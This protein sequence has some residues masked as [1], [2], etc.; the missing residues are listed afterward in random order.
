MRGISLHGELLRIISQGLKYGKVH[1][2]FNRT[3]NIIDDNGYMISLITKTLDEA[4]IS[5]LVDTKDFSSS[6][7]LIGKDVC[8]SEREVAVG[9]NVIDISKARTYDLKRGTFRAN[10]SL[11]E[12]N[13]K[14][15]RHLMD[16][17]GPKETQSFDLMA[18]QMVRS[19]TKS[20]KR[21]C[22][23]ED[24]KEMTILGRSL[25]GLGQ[26][27]TPSGDDVL[28][29]LFLVLGLEGSPMNYLDFILREIIQEKTEDTTD[30]SYQ[31]LLRASNG[32]YRSILVE[33]VEALTTWGNIEQILI[34]VL[35][36]GHSSGRDLLYGILTGYEILVEKENG[37][38]NE[39]NY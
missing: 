28:M 2:V 18:F 33:A 8:F 36:I 37:N 31:G 7:I 22:L 23:R 24:L 15:L 13:L 29:G 10:Y 9:S 25:M 19:R 5:I 17:K 32:F 20:L 35:S 6:G 27:L 21:A 1:S 14:I 16:T 4:P 26:G 34:E 3:I 39:D 11:L 30:V 38:V 12:K